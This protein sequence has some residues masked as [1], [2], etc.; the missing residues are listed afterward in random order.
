MQQTDRRQTKAS[1]NAPAYE[2]RGHNKPK[3]TPV[4]F[5]NDTRR[6]TCSDRKQAEDETA[7]SHTHAV[8]S[9]QRSQTAQ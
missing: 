8:P 6:L 4:S 1:L 7:L 5:N 9:W 2:G 3:I